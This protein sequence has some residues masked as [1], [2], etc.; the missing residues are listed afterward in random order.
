[1]IS[2]D[3]NEEYYSMRHVLSSLVGTNIPEGAGL[4]RDPAFP[5][6]VRLGSSKSGSTLFSQ[7]L[8]E[9]GVVGH[10]TNVSAL[11]PSSAV[12]GTIVSELLTNRRYRN[13]GEFDSLYAGARFQSVSGKTSGAGAP[14]EFW[15]FWFKF[16]SFPEVPIGPQEWSATADFA[17]FRTEIRAII[18][19]IS[20]PFLLKG[21]HLSHY[22]EVF[23][24]NVEN[25]IFIHAVRDP[26]E[27]IL[28]T[29]RARVVRYGDPDRFFGWKPLQY[30]LLEGLPRLI[31][32]AGQYYWNER[33]IEESAPQLGNRYFRVS[34]ESLCASPYDFVE[35]VRSKLSE[36]SAIPLAEQTGQLPQTFEPR[37]SDE[38]A[39]R[40]ASAALS[41]W[42]ERFGPADVVSGDTG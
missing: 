10:P 35:N 15:E 30:G 8:G 24:K 36:F 32:I 39:R 5:L 13:Y 3:R 38:A 18:N 37:K 28:S 9:S 40:A 34:H 2:F 26:L 21:H 7:V 19:V 4:V 14:A 27:V 41:Y 29:E 1:M 22:L 42:T 11:F 12:A 33:A 25:C 16:F 20:K 6:V 23:S 17:G 31:Q